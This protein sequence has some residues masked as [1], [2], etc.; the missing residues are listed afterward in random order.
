MN[1]S[2]VDYFDLQ[3]AK[4]IEEIADKMR[5]LNRAMKLG[6]TYID[7][8]LSDLYST[9]THFIFELLQNADDSNAKHVY[10]SLEEDR[11]IFTHDGDPFDIEDIKRIC[12]V[13]DSAKKMRKG[14][15]GQFGIG[16]K[17]VYSICKSPEIF[18]GDYQFRIK[19]YRVPEKINSDEIFYK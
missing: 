14:K 1:Q 11:L 19:D 6:N 8:I 16:F 17:S 4:T 7:E 2:F 9:P 5:N 13:N 18:S 10:L 12:A 15:I 3:H